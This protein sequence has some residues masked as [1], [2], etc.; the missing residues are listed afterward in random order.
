MDMAAEANP[1]SMRDPPDEED[2]E[3]EEEEVLEVPTDVRDLVGSLFELIITGFVPEPG[4][5]DWKQFQTWR[6]VEGGRPT[7]RRGDKRMLSTADESRVWRSSMEA[8]YGWIPGQ[9][10]TDPPGDAE[11]SRTNRVR[12]R[13]AYEQ[14]MSRQQELRML[15]ADTALASGVGT[16]ATRAPG[17]RTI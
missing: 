17:V 15:L 13:A 8:L 9:G 7:I 10:Q 12:A 14:R 5:L 1:F 2:P 4:P 6:A 3:A 11:E 16:D